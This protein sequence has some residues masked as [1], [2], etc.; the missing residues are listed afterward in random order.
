MSGLAVRPSFANTTVTFNVT[1]GVQTWTVPGGVTSATFDLW[2]A[3]GGS[4]FPRT[5]SGTGAAPGGQG[6]HV[7]ATLPVA[8]G[9]NL[10]IR[11]GGMGISGS[12]WAQGG[13][14]NGNGGFN[15]GGG[16]GTTSSTRTR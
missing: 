11:V 13:P 3:Q 2:G 4:S 5:Q 15:G 16:L 14:Y 10:E 6:A 9:T 1:G 8:G 7:E 12:Q